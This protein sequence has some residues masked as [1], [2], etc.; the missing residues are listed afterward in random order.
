MF[1]SKIDEFAVI[2]KRDLQPHYE[3]VA[4][5]LGKQDNKSKDRGLRQRWD[6][7]IFYVFCSLMRIRNPKYFDWWTVIN[8]AA[9]TGKPL[10]NITSYF[11]ITMLQYSMKRKID[12]LTHAKR[13]MNEIVDSSP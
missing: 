1:P 10:T 8:T 2:L 13:A 11:G 5:L 3:V 4:E 9:Y 6:R 7:Q 12:Q